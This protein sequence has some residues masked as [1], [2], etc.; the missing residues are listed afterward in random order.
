MQ[1]KSHCNDEIIDE[2]W[3]ALI[4]G[5]LKHGPKTRSKYLSYFPLLKKQNWTWEQIKSKIK[6][7]VFLEKAMTCKIFSA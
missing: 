3:Q 1:E 2:E 6:S 5:Y 4:Q 7:K